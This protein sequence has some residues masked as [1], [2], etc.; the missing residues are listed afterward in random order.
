MRLDTRNKVIRFSLIGFACFLL[1]L[2]IPIFNGCYFG[3]GGVMGNN[4]ELVVMSVL[5]PFF[6]ACCCLLASG[7]F[8][9]FTK[10]DA[11]NQI[12]KQYKNGVIS[13]QHYKNS[14]KEIELFELEKNK[15]LVEIEVEKQEFKNKLKKKVQNMQN[16]IKSK[17]GGEN[18]QA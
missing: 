13:T 12:E 16:D 6:S 5:F 2:F 3:L 1:I 11:I 4:G 17:K 10:Q 9:S 18:V 15:L 14:L 8:K 7:Y